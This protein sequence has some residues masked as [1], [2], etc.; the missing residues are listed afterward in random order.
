MILGETQILGQVRTSF[1]LAQEQDTIGTIFK[2]LFKEAITVAKKSHTETD[3]G[4]N[5]VSV[6][7]AAVELAKKIFGDLNE[8]HVTIVGAGKMGKLAIQNLQGSGA[9]KITVVNRTFE[10]AQALAQEFDGEACRIEELEKS[11]AQTDIVISST[12]S[13]SFVITK[14]MVETVEKSRK[15]KPLLLVDIAVPRDID[16]SN[17]KFIR[18]CLFIRY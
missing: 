7:Y 3:I 5:A 8:K 13:N 10:K 16:P 14:S 1:F 6:S 4:A 2:R 15:G 17:I 9:S 18:Q 12:G 11:L